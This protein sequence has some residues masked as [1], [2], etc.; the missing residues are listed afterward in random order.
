[1]R[2]AAANI[3]APANTSKKESSTYQFTNNQ[4]NAA[5]N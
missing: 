2:S 1:M 3:I 4:Q 5:G